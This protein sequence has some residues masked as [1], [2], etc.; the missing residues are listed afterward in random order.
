MHPAQIIR[1]LVVLSAP[2]VFESKGVTAQHL[3]SSP[4]QAA[5]EG[6]RFGRVRVRDLRQ[7][8]SRGWEAPRFSRGTG[9]GNDCFLPTP[10]SGVKTC[11]CGLGRDPGLC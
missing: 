4:R 7:A 8:S 9:F 2:H 11:L 3:G 1:D 6:V 10:D 5:H